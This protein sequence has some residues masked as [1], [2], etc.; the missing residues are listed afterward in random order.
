[1][2]LDLSELAAGIGAGLAFAAVF[3]R[4]TRLFPR[5]IAA[6]VTGIATLV[7]AGVTI[8]GV[9]PV[10][11]LLSLTAPLSSATLLFCARSLWLD[12]ARPATRTDPF[13]FR[14]MAAV[15]VL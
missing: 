6:V 5:P 3:A 9:T 11:Y 4:L 10:E 14:A 8:G 7:T 15:V 1:M 13:G 2:T 12:F